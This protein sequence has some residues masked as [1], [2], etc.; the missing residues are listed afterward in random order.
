MKARTYLI[1]GLLV[2]VCTF[3][4]TADIASAQKKIPDTVT[5]KPEGAMAPVTFSHILHT[6]KVRLDCS[7]CHHK[8]KDPKDAQA[9]RTCH[10][11]KGVKDNAPPAQDVFHKKCQTCHKESTAKG[12][13]APTQCTECHKK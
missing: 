1:I 9:C 6:Q 12:V 10:Q 13:K 3:I 11:A 4:L 7:T 5:L 2:F 8:D